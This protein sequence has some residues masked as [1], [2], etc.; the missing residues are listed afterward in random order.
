MMSE[1]TP[2]IDDD[3][4]QYSQ[5]DVDNM[6]KDQRQRCVDAIDK[7]DSELTDRGWEG[8]HSWCWDEVLDAC[9]SATG[10]NK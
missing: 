9:L 5:K 3:T 10:E 7:K 1:F 4:L 2:V 8:S 6:L